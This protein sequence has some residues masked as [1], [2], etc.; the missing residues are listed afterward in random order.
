MRWRIKLKESH[1]SKQEFISQ[2]ME[3]TWFMKQLRELPIQLKKLM[4]SLG[5]HLMTVYLKASQRLKKI[6]TEMIGP[7]EK[8]MEAAKVAAPP[9][10]VYEGVDLRVIPKYVSFKA[11]YEVQKTTYQY[12]VT[13]L[14]VILFG[15]LIYNVIYGYYV[16]K[17]LRQK[18]YLLVPSKITGITPATPQVVPDKYA[19]KAVTDFV[20]LLG[21]IHKGNV[22][23]NTQILAEHM[24][25][26]LKV[27]FLS[28]SQ[29]WIDRVIKEDVLEAVKPRKT[30]V[31]SDDSG[32]YDVTVLVDKDTYINN[33]FA[34]TFPEVIE[35]RLVV[36][37]P[38]D[39]QRWT[40]NIEKLSRSTNEDFK[41]KE[42]VRSG[43]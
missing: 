20:S 19:Q 1:L 36:V 3:N 41:R 11:A 14:L 27:R 25:D 35:M 37:N 31:I 39:S 6:G 23:E 28:E 21:N 4:K 40:L 26:N 24:A 33:R 12:I 10:G 34:G 2:K 16:D 42:S 32:H 17:K 8:G 43:H 18:E 38:K 30:Q 22:E 13:A 15:G 5:F 29:L 9:S 7:I